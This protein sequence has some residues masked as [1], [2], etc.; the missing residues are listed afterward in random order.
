MK[1]CEL[2]KLERRW[3]RGD[4]FDA[5][6]IITRKEA[7][8]RERF[9]ELAQVGYKVIFKSRRNVHWGRNA[10]YSARVLGSGMDWLTVY[11]Y[12]RSEQWL[13]YEDEAMK[14]YLAFQF[15]L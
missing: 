14:M 10:L 4:L 6:K 15:N 9:F 7:Q 5:Y 1:R 2:P 11:A 8:Q 12:Y 13:P 3:N